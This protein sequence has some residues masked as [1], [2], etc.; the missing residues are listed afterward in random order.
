MKNV[1]GYIIT[2][3][4]DEI[5]GDSNNKN[6]RESNL[7]RLSKYSQ[8]FHKVMGLP[9][10]KFI[11]EKRK[12]QFVN[13]IKLMYEDSRFL[14]IINELEKCNDKYD[15]VS[16]ADKDYFYKKLI[17]IE[18]KSG[19]V[20]KLFELDLAKESEILEGKEAILKSIDSLYK[21]I[22]S[23][24]K[25]VEVKHSLYQNLYN[26][27]QDFH[28]SFYSEILQIP[29]T[30]DLDRYNQRN[31]ICLQN[32]PTINLDIFPDCAKFLLGGGE[33]SSKLSN[34]EQYIKTTLTEKE[35]EYCEELYTNQKF[36]WENLNK[37]D[38]SILYLYILTY[39]SEVHAD[40]PLVN[41]HLKVD[42]EYSLIKEKIDD[43]L[44]LKVY[45][46]QN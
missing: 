1:K 6:N 32:I 40:D 7:R 39:P 21:I 2:E 16:Q 20:K 45:K 29:K 24:F 12:D 5:L 3:L 10:T 25:S 26:R 37:N 17:A 19:F 8:T 43:S 13:V 15:S 41:F 44:Y 23:N 46:D 28:T 9:A 38:I 30:T 34:E 18:S 27:L 42:A 11:Q 31:R 22:D 14:K 35:F 4:M 33:F 36:K